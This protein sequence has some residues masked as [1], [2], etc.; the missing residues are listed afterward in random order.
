M[1]YHETSEDGARDD[2]PVGHFHYRTRENREVDRFE[3]S[4]CMMLPRKDTERGG[5]CRIPLR[6]PSEEGDSPTW[7]WDG[8]IEHPTLTPSVFCMPRNPES[9]YHWHG[10]IVADRMV[11]C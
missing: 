6:P 2:W 9:P 8:N 11:G 4:L 5:Y 1:V 7:G 10:H 3:V